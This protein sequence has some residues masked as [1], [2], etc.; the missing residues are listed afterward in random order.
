MT[1]ASVPGGRGRVTERVA[2][3]AP[4]RLVTEVRDDQLAGRQ[5]VTFAAAGEGTL[6][7]VV[8]EYRL[9]RRGPLQAIA[10]A[11]FIRRALSDS[12]ARTLRRFAAEAAAGG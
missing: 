4:G 3:R 6:V 10:D 9:H 8:L 1:W 11:L 5:A 7:E 2:E 12:L